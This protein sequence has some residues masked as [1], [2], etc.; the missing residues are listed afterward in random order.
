M[1]EKT[2]H[3]KRYDLKMVCLLY[4]NFPKKFSKKLLTKVSKSPMILEVLKCT[5]LAKG[6]PLPFW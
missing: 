5:H 2:N 6:E 4:P 1:K 3:F